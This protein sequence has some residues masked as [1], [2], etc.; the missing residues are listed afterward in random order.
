MGDAPALDDPDDYLP[1]RLAAHVIVAAD[2]LGI[3][4]FVFMGHSWGASIG[5]HLAAEHAERIEALVLLDAGHT[6][7]PERSREELEREFT[8]DHAELDFESWDA[9]L[10]AARSDRTTWSPALEERYRA[11]MTERDGRIVARL[12]PEAAAWALHGVM[13]EP[14]SSAHERLGGPVLL[15]VASRNDTSEA[16]ARFLAAVPQADVR[17]VEAGHDVLG[18]APAETIAV[19]SDWLG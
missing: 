8:A 17:T 18:D 9:F 2:A 19:V 12:D 6:D 11:G 7:V 13:R 4:R 1:T 16:V 15:V 10:D 3:D 5:V 14:P